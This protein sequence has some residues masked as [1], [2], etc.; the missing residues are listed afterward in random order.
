M[1]GAK[2]KLAKDK[3]PKD[4]SPK[5]KLAKDK[6]AKAKSAKNKSSKKSAVAVRKVTGTKKKNQNKNAL[7]LNSGLEEVA[8]TPSASSSEENDSEVDRGRVI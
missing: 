4:K 2:V 5:D 6:S 1:G 8:P 3:S 7:G